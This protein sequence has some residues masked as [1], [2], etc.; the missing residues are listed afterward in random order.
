ME[1]GSIGGAC[2]MGDAGRLAE[3]HRA[4]LMIAIWAQIIRMSEAVRAEIQPS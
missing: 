3:R 4:M 1:T 2:D